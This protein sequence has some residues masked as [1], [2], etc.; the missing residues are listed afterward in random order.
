MNDFTKRNPPREKVRVDH[1]TGLI[2]GLPGGP[3]PLV[4]PTAGREY[5]ALKR[6]EQKHAA[7]M[8]ILKRQMAST[9]QCTQCKRTFPGTVVRVKF[10]MVGGVPTQ[11]LVCPDSKCDAPVVMVKEGRT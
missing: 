2:H 7:A 11:L 10:P 5:E 8:Q 6:N 1:E 9:F 3:Q 4:G